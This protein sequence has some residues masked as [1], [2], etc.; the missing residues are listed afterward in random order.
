MEDAPSHAGVYALWRGETLLHL[1]CAREGESIRD[2]LLAHLER[3]Q[4]GERPT[5][6][7]WEITAEPMR[8]AWELATL[9]GKAEPAPG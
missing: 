7:S 5:H 9:L 4:G 2:K 6:Y 3:A 1:G 8:R